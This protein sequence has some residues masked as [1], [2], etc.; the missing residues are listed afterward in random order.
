MVVRPK[1]RSAVERRR[2]Q[3][4]AQLEHL[5]LQ[6]TSK[7]RKDFTTDFRHESWLGQCRSLIDEL[8]GE[9]SALDEPGEYDELPAAVVADEL[10][11]SLEKIKLLIKLGEV[12]AEGRRAHE[13]ISRGELERLAQIGTDEILR[14]AE[15]GADVVF[16]Q[17]VSLLR[18][19]D[20]ASAERSYLRLRARETSI[21]NFALATEVAIKLSKGIYA[22]AERTIEFIL[23]EKAYERRVV[24]SYLADFAREVCFKD[25]EARIIIARLVQP[26]DNPTLT[27]TPMGRTADYLQVTAMYITTV[28][29]DGL[30]ELFTQAPAGDQRNELYRRMRDRIFS[31]LYAEANSDTSLKSRTFVLTAKQK[32]PRYWEPASLLDELRD[33]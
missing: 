8:L 24:S 7:T 2:E 12:E 6:L 30:E 31:S 9:L 20:V 26:L 32:L 16:G 28:V 13:R 33:D 23:T 5:R 14:R 1:K 18:S 22:E 27:E 3:I 10:G 15:E 19:G 25:E 29:S 4:T 11:L 21:G 17:A